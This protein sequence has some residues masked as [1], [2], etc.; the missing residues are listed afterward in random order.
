MH[1]S[2]HGFS[3]WERFQINTTR[4][5]WQ[6]EN[7][8]CLFSEALPG[9][10]GSEGKAWG[11]STWAIM[12]YKYNIYED[13]TKNSLI[14]T[15]VRQ[16]PP[17]WICKCNLVHFLQ[18]HLELVRTDLQNAYSQK[19]TLVQPFFWGN[20]CPPLEKTFYPRK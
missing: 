10:T 1:I 13:Y 16:R 8:L 9:C 4:K 14:K 19:C 3:F 20:V 6:V 12:K 5:R 15:L 17:K 18:I 2:L 7:S 11:G